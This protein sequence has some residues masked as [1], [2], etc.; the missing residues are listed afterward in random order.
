[1]SDK[2]YTFSPKCGQA[3]HPETRWKKDRVST[4]EKLGF[5][6]GSECSALAQQ[7]TMSGPQIPK[8]QVV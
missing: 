8:G 5:S 7:G 2:V 1:M 6:S 3:I 4:E